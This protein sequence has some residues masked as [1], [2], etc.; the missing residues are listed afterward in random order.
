[1]L[2]QQADQGQSASIRLGAERLVADPQVDAAIFSVVDQ[3]FLTS[4]IFETL[5][6]AWAM[7]PA[8]ICVATYAGQRGNPALFPRAY[9]EELM[10]LRGDVG[11]RDVVRGHPD[12]VHEV[13]MSDPEAGRDIDTWDEYELAL[14]EH[15][16]HPPSR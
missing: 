11:G 10:A 3:P 7:R 9:F 12:A 15:G 1:M 5:I 8:T 16:Q 6:S 13:P 2:N 14:A 4:A